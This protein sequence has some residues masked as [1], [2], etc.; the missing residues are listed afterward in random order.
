MLISE[1]VIRKNIKKILK[2][3]INAENDYDEF[4]AIVYAEPEDVKNLDKGFT[5]KVYY[6]NDKR[7]Y[8][9]EH[10]KIFLKTLE[11]QNFAILLKRHSTR[12]DP[13]ANEEK[14]KEQ[15]NRFKKHVES[16]SKNTNIFQL[17]NNSFIYVNLKKEEI[18]EDFKNSKFLKFKDFVDDKIKNDNKQSLQYGLIKKFVLEKNIDVKDSVG[19][20]IEEIEDKQENNIQKE[21]DVQKDF[22]NIIHFQDKEQKGRDIIDGKENVENQKEEKG[23]LSSKLKL[24]KKSMIEFEKGDISKD[25]FNER[26]KEIIKNIKDQ[27]RVLISDE[28]LEKIKNT[29]KEVPDVWS[30]YEE[31]ILAKYRK[32]NV[33]EH[34]KSDLDR[35]KEE[36]KRK[37][38]DLIKYAYDNK[39]AILGDKILILYLVQSR[40]RERVSSG[41]N[42][43]EKSQMNDIKDFAEKKGLINFYYKHALGESK[44]KTKKIMT[45]RQLREFI[46]NSLLKEISDESYRSLQD[47]KEKDKQYLIKKG[48]IKKNV[49]SPEDSMI[50]SKLWNPDDTRSLEDF[51]EQIHYEYPSAFSEEGKKMYY[52]GKRHLKKWWWE[53]H[54]KNLFNNPNDLKEKKEKIVV[55]H[56]LL[57]YNPQGYGKNLDEFCN[58]YENIYKDLK[59]IQ[60]NELSAI[61]Y[62]NLEKI[63]VYEICKGLISPEIAASSAGILDVFFY[64]NPRVITHASPSDSATEKFSDYS[65]DYFEKTK[66]S[67]TRK[68]PLSYG[69]SN[70][71]R[72]K[73]EMEWSNVLDEDDV[74]NKKF[75]GEVVVGNWKIDS[76]WFNMNFSDILQGFKEEVEKNKDL[77]FKEHTEKNSEGLKIKI[78]Y[79]FALKGLKCFDKKG[80]LLQKEIYLRIQHNL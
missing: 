71:D 1:K 20:I 60:K 79:F 68:Y 10:A 21:P 54:D 25:Q 37:I 8:D 64:L 42:D 7:N 23:D 48:A 36:Y 50:F 17:L 14:K 46:R 41:F 78:L 6:F 5:A 38:K 12:I 18:E 34:N 9:A 11:N 35:Y 32:I 57:A 72:T 19:K 24:L 39:K 65:K 13:Y 51:E 58:H 66:E 40:K 26:K 47:Y 43:K 75:I 67:G 62:V 29:I 53:N 70:F 52:S 55:I 74:K 59:K 45:E 69:S 49:I 77:T 33:E 61:G 73:Q 56:N 80:N 30:N 4:N 76:V 27:H 31:A 2:E 63:D 22:G 16:R 15:I 44:K 28:H 3:A